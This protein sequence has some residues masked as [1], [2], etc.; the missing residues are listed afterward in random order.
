MPNLPSDLEI[1]LFDLR[2]YIILENALTLQE[3]TTINAGIDGLLPIE[4]GQWD[5][6]VHAT[7]FG[8]QQGINL[9]QIYEAGEHFERLIDH[10][11]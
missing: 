8:T 6:Y 7:N 10:P 9:Q 2:G 5:G 1:Y 11:C 4:D 3:V